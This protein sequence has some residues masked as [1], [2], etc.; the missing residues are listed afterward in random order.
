MKHVKLFSLLITFILVLN[1]ARS[2]E[3]DSVENSFYSSSSSFAYSSGGKN[4]YHV[5][6][7]ECHYDPQ[8][9]K[10]V[11][12]HKHKDKVADS[13]EVEEYEEEFIKDEQNTEEGIDE[14]SE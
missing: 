14:F 10:T 9:K 5:D 11:C 3:E 6:T 13:D 12:K 1:S 2:E 4:E 8:I 7:E